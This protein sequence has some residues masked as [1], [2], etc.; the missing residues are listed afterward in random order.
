MEEDHNKEISECLKRIENRLAKIED[1]L[2]G[3]EK[4]IIQA[5]P[6]DHVL[7]E[8]SFMEFYLEYKSKT[9]TDKTLVVMDFLEKMRGKKEATTKDIS[10]AFREVREKVPLNIS[11]KIQMLHKKGFV[12]PGEIINGLRGWTITRK[13]LMYLEELKDE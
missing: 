13:G 9:A 5:T 12:M 10:E 11:D 7:K 4:V 6:E 2:L 1:K 8:K 3:E